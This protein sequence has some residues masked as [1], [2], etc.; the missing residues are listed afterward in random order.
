MEKQ[1]LLD[2][3]YGAVIGGA[4]GDAIGA[5]VEGWQYQEIRAKYGRLNDLIANDQWGGHAPAGTITDDTTLRQYLSLAIVQ[6]GGRITVDDAAAMLKEKLNEERFWL[7]EKIVKIKLRAGMNPL[8]VGR[9]CIPAGCAIMGISP[10]G[11]I[12]AGNPEQA[13]QD[14]LCIASLNQDLAERDAAA[15][16]AAGVA[17]AFTPGATV[18]TII[19]AMR[20]NCSFVVWRAMEFAL[21]IARKTQEVDAFI[22]QFYASRLDWTAALPEGEFKIDRYFSPSALEILPASIGLFYLFN[23]DVNRCIVEGGSFGRD[24]DTIGG[25]VGALAGAYKGA[26]AIRKDWIDQVEEANKPFFTELEGDEKCNFYHMACRLVEAIDKERLSAYK[27]ARMLDD[28]L[29]TAQ[30]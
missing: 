27:R 22:E 2:K 9:G 21:E 1:N 14:G 4:I 20:S 3:V 6:K 13:Y 28:I 12:N 17:A 8:D 5:P 26:S 23:G 15:T 11:I 25:V 30:N 10:I 19:E 7:N 29:G 16:M 18:Q 24:C